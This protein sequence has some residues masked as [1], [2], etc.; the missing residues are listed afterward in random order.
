MLLGSEVSVKMMTG[1]SALMLIAMSFLAA[2]CHRSSDA[3]VPATAATQTIAP[4][5]APSAP[6]GTDAM[7]QTVDVEDSR[8][9]AEGGALDNTQTA[10]AS[11]VT[12]TSKPGPKP[13][14]KPTK[15]K[16]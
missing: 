8:S 15:R 14:L 2:G 1:R 3:Q 12:T 16:K 4:A 6:N 13:A 5:A 10:T 7:T 9:E 11:T